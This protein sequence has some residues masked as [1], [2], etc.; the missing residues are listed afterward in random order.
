MKKT[1]EGINQLIGPKRKNCKLLT[2]LKR[3]NKKGLTQN[4]Y[5]LT[6]I[7]NRYYTSVGQKLT[8]DVPSSD[9]HFSE[10]LG[11]QA[12][13]NSFFFNPVTSPEVESEIM[14]TPFNKAYGL[15]FCPIRI[16]KGAKLHYFRHFG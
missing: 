9:R 15:Y 16:L 6:D 11:N 3:P 14:S 2:A 8:E 5:E 7:L 10:Y 13:P 4:P 1:R 12:Y